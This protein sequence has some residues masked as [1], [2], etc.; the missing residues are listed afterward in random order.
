MS[1]RDMRGPACGLLAAALFGLSA[2]IGKMLVA[3][4]GPLALA[5]VFYLAAG[6]LLVLITRARARSA[7]ALFLRDADARRHCHPRRHRWTVLM[8]YGLSKV[9]V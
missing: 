6:V 4:A 7:E 9:S 8:L 3:H 2:P 1:T 5:S